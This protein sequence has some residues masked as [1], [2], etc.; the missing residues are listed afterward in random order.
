M[1]AS[2]GLDDFRPFLEMLFEGCGF[3]ERAP[4]E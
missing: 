4:R 3:Q 2:V 1:V